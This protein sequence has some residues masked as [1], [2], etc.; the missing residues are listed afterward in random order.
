MSDERRKNETPNDPD[1]DAVRAAWRELPAEEPPELLDQAVLNR[2]RRELETARPR[3]LRW[4]GPFA[5]AGVAVIA[6]SVWLLQDASP[7]PSGSDEVLRLEPAAEPAPPPA[8]E[9]QQ[10]RRL[11]P[12]PVTGREPGTAASQSR[13]RAPSAPLAEA[14]EATPDAVARTGA[15]ADEAAEHRPPDVWIRDMLAL[16]AAG[17]TAELRAE[18]AAFR[19]AYPEYT[20][21]PS[22]QG[23]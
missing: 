1:L 17:R 12:S 3:R 10:E 7:P 4:I 9:K 2:A 18:L 19:A 13:A 16:Q 15:A 11:A 21:P 20:L 6:L 5:T 22:L 23:E 14:N 8:R